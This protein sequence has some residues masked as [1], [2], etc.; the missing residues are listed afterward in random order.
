[1]T[2]KIK[3]SHTE[4]E[5][6]LFLEVLGVYGIL[7]LALVGIYYLEPAI[8]GFVTVT[9]EFNYTDDVNLEFSES[10]EYTWNLANPGNLKSVKVSG[11]MDDQGEARVYIENNGI[12]HLIFDSTQLVEKESG[13]F[14]ITGFAVSEDGESGVDEDSD[15][16][17]EEG[18]EIPINGTGMINDTI[19]NETEIIN[20]TAINETP[21]INESIEINETVIN[22]TTEKIININ[23]LW[24]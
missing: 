24:Q 12:R 17:E 4:V 5:V 3:L 9:K 19:I 18:E 13:M 16:G 14:G 6:K 10:A 1:M 11:N 20:Q 21:I 2:R 22:E 8:T 15:E 7:A 23:G